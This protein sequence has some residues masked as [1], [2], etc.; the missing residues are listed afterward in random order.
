VNPV[1][2]TVMVVPP[3]AGP[4]AG[5]IAVTVMAAE[6]PGGVFGGGVGLPCHVYSAAVVGVFGPFAVMT[7]MFVV[8]LPMVDGAAGATAVSVVSV[9][10]AKLD[11]GVCPKKTLV[12]PVKLVPVMLTCVAPELGPR[13]GLT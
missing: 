10:T 13:L 12:A 6:V 8:M 2:V 3:A 11:A 4:W 1:P 9:L 5:L 7:V